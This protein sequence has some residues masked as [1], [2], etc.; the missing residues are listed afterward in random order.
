MCNWIMLART[1][2]LLHRMK[3]IRNGLKALYFCA[4]I[5][6]GGLVVLATFEL[7]GRMFRSDMLHACAIRE[8]PRLMPYIWISPMV[9]ET[10]MFGTTVILVWRLNW[11]MTVSASLGFN[12]WAVLFRDG[13]WYYLIII[14]LR[15]IN[16]ASWLA[17]PAAYS[18]SGLLYAP[19][20]VH[21]VLLTDDETMLFSVLW[22]VMSVSVTRLQ[23]NLSKSANADSNTS[24][25]GYTM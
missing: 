9:F 22:A 4:Y 8:L 6:T 15:G 2:A 10:V 25:Y 3:L 7:Q 1:S 19:H 24:H 5:A 13:V 20:L 23:I 17:L 16:L 11:I 12:L 18:F 21:Y 14:V